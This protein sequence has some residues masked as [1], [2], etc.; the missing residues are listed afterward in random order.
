MQRSDLIFIAEPRNKQNLMKKRNP[1]TQVW[2]FCFSILLVIQ[3][4]CTSCSAIETPTTPTTP[5]TEA[6]SE[7]PIPNVKIESRISPPTIV[8]DV[9]YFGTEAGI[10]YAMNMT[11]AREIWRFQANGPLEWQPAVADGMVYIGGKNGVL[12]ALDEKNGELI[13]DFQAGKVDWSVRDIFINGTPTIQN[14]LIYFSSEDFNVYALDAKSGE[15][16]W[17]LMLDEEP[18]AA[19][20]PIKNGLAYIGDWSGSLYAIDVTTGKISWQTEPITDDL[21]STQVPHVTAVPILVGD[22]VFYTDW[23]GKLFAVDLATGQYK[24]IFAPET[25]NVRQ[26]GSR[27]YF[28]HHDAV[29]FYSTVE[30]KHLYGVD[31]ETGKKVWEWEYV[32]KGWLYGPFPGAKG[33][34]LV[35]E[36]IR[37]DLSLHGLD[38]ETK[39]FLWENNEITGIPTVE[40]DIVYFGGVDGTLH[41]LDILTGEDVWKLGK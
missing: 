41:G 29:L 9:V 15:E 10:L 39:E 37:G 18:Q 25:L 23:S 32:G 1:T 40:N 12:Y 19:E 7:R 38:L 8:S 20:L 2:L 22:E 33:V 13:W 26:A 36:V 6:T 31:R 27:T 28:A 21:S 30:D 24:W 35:L 5:T 4:L 16:Q 11:T 17:R 14:G 3:A 34:G